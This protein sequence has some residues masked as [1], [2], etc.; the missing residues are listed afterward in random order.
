MLSKSIS[1]HLRS[2]QRFAFNLALGPFRPSYAL[3]HHCPDL[4]IKD[5]YDLKGLRNFIRQE[6]K[7]G[8][9]QRHLLV[10]VADKREVWVDSGSHTSVAG[11]AGTGKSVLEALMVFQRVA[12]DMPVLVLDWV[13]DAAS[14]DLI[15]TS[16]EMAEMKPLKELRISDVQGLNG[17]W[18][19]CGMG[20]T[21]KAMD[22][23]T[24]VLERIAHALSSMEK[25]FDT[26]QMIV[27]SEADWMFN[28]SESRATELVHQLLRQAR[29]KN[30]AITLFFQK[31]DEKALA[32]STT[33]IEF[34]QKMQTGH[35]AVRTGSKLRSGVGYAN[36]YVIAK[37]PFFNPIKD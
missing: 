26:P 12:L 11:V 6:R 5:E 36:E 37:V 21:L 9:T 28:N 1:Y 2:V 35:C 13:G 18:Q 33:F 32:Q 3:E 29:S 30:V 24:L 4:W 14:R 20:D 16:L 22:E 15:Q 34:N 27:I 8:I 25:P 23:M 31:A 10:G 17:L 7:P 19:S